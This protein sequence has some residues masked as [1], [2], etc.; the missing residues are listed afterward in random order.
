VSG[1]A[2]AAWRVLAPVLLLLVLGGC[3]PGSSVRSE[4]PTPEEEPPS[5]TF[6]G[7]SWTYGSGV[8]SGEGYVELVTAQLGWRYDNQGIIGSGY[9]TRGQGR[10]YGERLTTAVAGRPDLIVVQG[11]LNDQAVDAETLAA[12]A[13]DTLDRLRDRAHPDTEILVMGASHTPAT[14]DATIDAIN[15]AVGEA[16]RAVGL[17]FV[18]PAVENWTDPADPDVWDDGNH[19]NDT[20]HQQIADGLAPILEDVLDR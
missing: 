9:W 6:V 17:P 11:S 3:A 4:E 7:D 8:R 12:R 20:G 5:V 19:P 1:A 16:A 13:L 10:P 2:T 14:P 15:R 18:D